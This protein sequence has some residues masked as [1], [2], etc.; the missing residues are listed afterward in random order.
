VVP[1]ELII[2]AIVLMIFVF[3][4]AYPVWF[5]KAVRKRRATDPDYSPPRPLAIVDELYH[6]DA[7][8]TRQIVEDER[9]IPAKAPLP[10]DKS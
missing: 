1:V 4:F 2:I 5:R 6:P 8:A 10:G 9:V 3:F 7:H